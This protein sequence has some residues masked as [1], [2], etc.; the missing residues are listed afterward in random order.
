MRVPV[1][2]ALA[3]LA[4]LLSSLVVHADDVAPTD[5]QVA[6]PVYAA[7]QLD[8]EGRLAD[9]L[10][11]YA[12]RARETVTLADRLR[13]A[14]ALL[15]ARQTAE[16]RAVFDEVMREEGS[17]E[18]GRAT[19]VHAAAASASTALAAGAP[20]VAVDYARAAATADGREAGTRLLLV[21]ALAAA[22]DTAGACTL[23]KELAAEADGW[24]DGRRTELAR[25]QLLTGDTVSAQ[26]ALARTPPESVAQMFRDSVQAYQL[27]I[28]HDW[29]KAAE[30][31]RAS[32]RKVPPG[33]DDGHVDQ[34]WRNAQR[35]LRWVRLR[36]AVAL[37]HSGDRREAIAEA[38][39]AT[40]SD[41]A[42]VT[43]T[44]ALLLAAGD[45]AAGRR[46]DAI[47]KLQA[48][49]GHDYR[50]A[51]PVDHLAA[52]LEA[53]RDPGDAIG[54]IRAVVASQDRSADAVT[55]PLL[56]AVSGSARSR[57]EPSPR[58]PVEAP[59]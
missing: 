47:A 34:S 39:K 1:S 55:T 58:G 33:L 30:L 31:L 59:H 15:R 48:L 28:H 14:G 37:W 21:R 42:Y 4:G 38:G 5:V 18:H 13:Y 56:D 57:E 27:L 17:V 24:S 3:V 51:E 29:T 53:G 49:A 9:A 35:E 45:L 40:R 11:L 19:R 2:L 44:A 54:E 8:D 10:P 7:R 32:E 16:A 22:G 20:A 43:S 52:S 23:L 46:A 12:E 36:R 25:W 41:E 50:F 6:P 26:A